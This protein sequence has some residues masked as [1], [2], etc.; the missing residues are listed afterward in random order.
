M[1]FESFT[2]KL[3]RAIDGLELGVRHMHNDDI[4]D[5]IW[6][7]ILNNEIKE[8]VV[9]LKVDQPGNPAY[10]KRSYRIS[11]LKSRSYLR[12]AILEGLRRK[13]LCHRIVN[14]PETAHVLQQVL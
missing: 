10:I 6:Q 12:I 5:I 14:I 9:A 2:E 3:Q 7:K 8:F 13:L 1:L 4:V 11:P